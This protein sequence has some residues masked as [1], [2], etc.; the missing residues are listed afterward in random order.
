[1]KN[2]RKTVVNNISLNFPSKGFYSIIGK[3]CSGWKIN[4]E[5]LLIRIMEKCGIRSG[6]YFRV[7]DEK[8]GAYDADG[9]YSSNREN[10]HFD[11]DN[12][13]CK[14]YDSIAALISKILGV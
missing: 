11:L 14:S 12:N 2:R 4:I 1:M 13:M 3:S 5:T 10:T 9:N 7:S 8:N 6:P